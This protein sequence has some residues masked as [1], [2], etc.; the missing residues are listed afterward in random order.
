M[1][2]YSAHFLPYRY[3]MQAYGAS[4]TAQA[5]GLILGTD[6]AKCILATVDTL[7]ESD[8]PATEES[9]LGSINVLVVGEERGNVVGV[10]ALLFVDPCRKEALSEKSG[11]LLAP[12][13]RWQE[14]A[15]KLVMPDYRKLGVSNELSKVMDTVSK[16]VHV[17]STCL[18]HN[19]S[20]INNLQNH[21]FSFRGKPFASRINPDHSVGLLTN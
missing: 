10:S 7:Q 17:F 11:Y 1:I 12:A 6:R 9:I 2:Q 20:S 3:G 5:K 8:S 19:F 15:Y 21:G 4:T 18:L 14:W 13:I 16:S